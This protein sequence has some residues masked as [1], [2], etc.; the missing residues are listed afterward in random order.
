MKQI[1]EKAQLRAENAIFIDDNIVNLNE[2]KFYNPN[3]NVASPKILDEILL[4][5]SFQE[6][7]ISIELI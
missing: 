7:M 4:L 3:I 1:L 5:D 6:K 2:V